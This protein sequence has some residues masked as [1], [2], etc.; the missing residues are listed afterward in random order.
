LRGG[1]V[2]SLRDALVPDFAL[3]HMS[4]SVSPLGSTLPLDAV[5]TSLDDALAELQRRRND[6]ALCGR[7]M[8]L[9]ASLPPTFLPDKPLA[10]FF[11]TILSPTHELAWFLKA[12]EGTGLEPL[13]LEYGKDRYVSC[14]R[15]KYRLCRLSF[16]DEH[17]VIGLQ[18]VKLGSIEGQRVRLEEIRTKNRA[19]LRALHHTLLQ[20]EHPH[21]ASHVVDFSEWFSAACKLDSYYFRY[22]SLFITHGILFENF[23]QT[24]E[25]ELMFAQERVLPSFEAV[26][27]HFGVRPL[28]VPLLPFETEG[29]D[30]WRSLPS[31]LYPAACAFLKR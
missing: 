24:D 11:R 21:L 20:T 6:S 7:V 3:F 2:H 31:S 29:S 26:T 23:L 14:N 18:A 1:G 13:L 4:I 12:I 10:V 5:Y 30:Y 17:G 8:E 15:D 9:H 28:I 19:P 27:N 22:L 16:T 25:K